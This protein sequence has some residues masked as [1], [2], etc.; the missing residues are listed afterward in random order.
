MINTD[1]EETWVEEDSSVIHPSIYVRDPDS[2]I[3]EKEFF[4]WD[5]NGYLV[6]RGLMDEQWLR[7]QMRRLTNSKIGSS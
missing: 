1:G 6:V 3:D 2:G 4:F 5:L 7:R